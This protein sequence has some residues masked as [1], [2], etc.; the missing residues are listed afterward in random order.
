PNTISTPSCLSS[1]RNARFPDMTGKIVSS[2]FGCCVNADVWL[3]AAPAGRWILRRNCSA[4]CTIIKQAEPCV[5]ARLWLPN[6]WSMPVAAMSEFDRQSAF[7]GTKE[8]A[9][10]LRLDVAGLQSYLQRHV[11]DFSGPLTVSQFKGGQ[12]N[13]TYLLT[14]PQRSYVLRRKPPGKL[15]PSA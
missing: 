10:P 1:S 11:P 6:P 5:P 7:A 14:T 12:S 3:R 9:A 15:L 13:P 2:S 8:V 4:S